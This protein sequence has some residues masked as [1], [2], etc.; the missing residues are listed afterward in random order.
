MHPKVKNMIVVPNHKKVEIFIRIQICL[1]SWMNFNYKESGGKKAFPYKLKH[2][3]HV[4]KVE[5]MIV[6]PNKKNSGDCYEYPSLSHFMD[7]LL[8]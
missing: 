3:Y 4:S 1:I 6:V 7:A 2:Y 8:L 5:N